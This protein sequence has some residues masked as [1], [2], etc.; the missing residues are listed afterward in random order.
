[1]RNRWIGI[2]VAAGFA[3]LY[4]PLLAVGVFSFNQARYGVEWI[5]FTV[6]WYARLW[7]DERVLEAARNSLLLATMSAI[8]ATLLGTLLALG[9]ARTPWPRAARGALETLVRLPVVT[10]DIILAA[11]I[12]VAFAAARWACAA[13]GAPSSAFEPGMGQMIVGHVAFEI[14][15]VALVVGARL[16]VIGKEQ[17]EA[18][19][20]LYAD[21]HLF[22]L[23]VLLPQ[24]LPG[25]AAGAILAFT[26]SL[27]D[28]VVS[29]FTAGPASATLPLHIYAAVRRGLSPEIHALSTV[30][31]AAAVALVAIF[32]IL[33]RAKEE[34]R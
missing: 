12:V 5:G 17:E 1:M 30:V 34:D 20:D 14:P 28:F 2:P 33:T 9:L 3:L 18:A 29:F 25:I 21:T 10:P 19:R 31:F 6:E 7:S 4:L 22:H 23:R 27:D 11:C 26:L 15:F 32:T 24:L 8:I 16:A 13:L